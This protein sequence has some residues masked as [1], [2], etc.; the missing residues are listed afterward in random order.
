[1]AVAKHFIGNEQ[2][3]QRLSVNS[4][5]DEKT[6][7]ELY[8]PPFE[9]AIKAGVMAIMCSYNRINGAYACDNNKTLNGDLRG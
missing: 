3:T 1:M 2:E 6:L 7:N 4:E 9:G 8:Y 5:I